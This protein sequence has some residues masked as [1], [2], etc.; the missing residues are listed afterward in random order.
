[1]TKKKKISDR[2]GQKKGQKHKIGREMAGQRKESEN[3]RLED[4]FM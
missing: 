2:L 1:M 4:T 3:R